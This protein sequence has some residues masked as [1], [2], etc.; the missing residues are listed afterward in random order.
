MNIREFPNKATA[1]AV[2]E[3]DRPE[4]EPLPALMLA[5]AG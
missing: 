1:V 4:I 2:I 5:A 3:P